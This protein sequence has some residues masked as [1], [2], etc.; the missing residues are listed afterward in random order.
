MNHPQQG[1]YIDI[2]IHGGQPAA[3]LFILE[4]L[5]AHEDKLPSSTEGVA[6]TYG[7]HP[8]FLSETNLSEQLDKVR[9]ITQGPDIIAI[10]E[11]GF[12]RLR[13]PSFDL[14]RKAF[15]EQVQISE[16]L[17]KPLIIHCV[18]SWEELVGEMRDLKPEM[19]WM[20]HGFRG[21]IPLAKQLLSKGFYLSVWFDFALRP[22]SSELLRNIAR[23]RLFLETDGAEVD[24]RWIYNKVSDDLGI[25]E[26]ELKQIAYQNYRSF[27]SL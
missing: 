22:E 1:D 18:R 12:D 6:Y 19:P 14:Q 16:N 5:M 24:I 8:W 3:G 2:H 9:K 21:K 27:F 17:R 11:A 23:N 4:S 10:G 26:E 20:V 7:I 25:N 13:G 15:R